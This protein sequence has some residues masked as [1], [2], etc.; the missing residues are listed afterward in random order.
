MRLTRELAWAIHFGGFAVSLVDDRK[1]L[2]MQRPKSGTDSFIADPYQT[3][4]RLKALEDYIYGDSTGYLG[5]PRLVSL[6]GSNDNYNRFERV[7]GDRIHSSRNWTS[8][9]VVRAQD[10]PLSDPQNDLR[11]VLCMAGGALLRTQ[12]G[13]KQIRAGDVYFN[14]GKNY[15]LIL[16]EGEYRRV[17]IPRKLISGLDHTMD[18]FHII[19]QTDPVANV[20]RTAVEGL[21]VESQ[22][23]DAGRAR[24]ASDLVITISQKVLESLHAS[25]VHSHYEHIRDRAME[26]IRDNLGRADLSVAEVTNYVHV[27]RAT[28]YRSFEMLGGLKEFVTSE[29]IAAAKVML[30]S[31]RTD[32]GHIATVAYSTGFS[33]PEHFSKV[34]KA[35]TGMSPTQFIQNESN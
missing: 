24:L 16:S 29:R 9:Y 8:G 14:I 19:A 22:N 27:S 20:I 17:V 35:R 30:R 28:L 4:E 2:D 10:G 7:Y 13:E 23:G 21:S 5:D 15:Q 26:Y 25:S 11:I 12:H 6:S 18:Q 34:F 32:R 3:E 1:S 33:T 31:G